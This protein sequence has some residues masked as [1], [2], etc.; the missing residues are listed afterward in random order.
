MCIRDSPFDS[1]YMI[2]VILLVGYWF[3]AFCGSAGTVLMMT[4]YQ[5]EYKNILI[6]SAIIS[7]LSSIILVH[8]WGV[9]GAAASVSLT[10]I[11]WNAASVY[12]VKVKH[13]F[14][15][16]FDY[17]YSAEYLSDRVKALGV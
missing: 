9:Y 17:R 15:C 5:R 3:N 11:G 4:E 12:L 14:W 1:G 7:L 2:L 10:M 16:C 13:K 6:V 8:F